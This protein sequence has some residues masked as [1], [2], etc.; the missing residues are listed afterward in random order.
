[1]NPI[2]AVIIPH[3]L[4]RPL[5]SLPFL[6]KQTLK[7]EYV[8][9]V[10]D[11]EGEGASACRNDGILLFERYVNFF[12]F[13]DDDLELKPDALENLYKTLIN[14]P[15]ASYSYGF[16]E[17]DG[18]IISKQPFDENLLKKHNYINTMI[19]IINHKLPFFDKNLKRF[20]DWDYM[21]TLLE[22]GK[23]GVF[24]DNLIFKTHYSPDGLTN[25]NNIPAGEAERIVREKHKLCP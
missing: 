7:P 12:F 2:I 23:R 18:N 21:L 22:D 24:C 15:D 25:D 17:C 16:Y 6:E 9:V 13:C 14:S 4:G 20:Q 1:M 11:L 19:L 8:L 5:I 10:N 3:K